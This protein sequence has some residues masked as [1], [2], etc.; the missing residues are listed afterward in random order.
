MLQL[1]AKFKVQSAFLIAGCLLLSAVVRW[2]WHQADVALEA[3]RSLPCGDH[4]PPGALEVHTVFGTKREKVLVLPFGMGVHGV[5]GD[6]GDLL[7]C[8]HVMEVEKVELYSAQWV[9]QLQKQKES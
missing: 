5:E 8:C 6:D 2:A 4:L 9:Q 7:N 3:W 1:R